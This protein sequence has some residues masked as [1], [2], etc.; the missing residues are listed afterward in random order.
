MSDRSSYPA[1]TFSWA[2]LATSDGEAAK[3]FYTAV[4]GWTYDDRP[5][6]PDMVYSMAQLDGRSAAALFTS[7]QPPHWNCYVT[8]DDVDAAAARAGELGATIVAEP[9]DVMTAGRSAVFTDPAGATLCLWQ[10][11]ENPG[12]GVV[13]EPGAMTW[14]DLVTADAEAAVHLLRG[15][16]RLGVRGARGRPGLPVI[17][18]GGRPNGGIMPLPPEQAGSTPP[19]WMPY[20]GHRTST[21]SRARSA[22]SA[23]RSTRSRSTS[24][25]AGSPSSAIRRERCS[26]SGPGPTTRT[27]RPARPTAARPRRGRGASR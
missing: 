17:R 9:F 10:A 6:G 26:R 12:A 14:T 22:A 21:R 5:V 19:N 3:P 13:N 18:N 24:S 4:F 1:G 20:F 8:V 16:V 23:G 27:R 11:G 2:E 15:P 7:D 25:R